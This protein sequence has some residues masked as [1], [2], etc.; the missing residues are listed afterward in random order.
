MVCFLFFC[1]NV[2][3]LFGYQMTVIRV[4][5]ILPLGQPRDIMPTRRVC[6]AVLLRESF[7]KITK[8]IYKIGAIMQLYLFP[9]PE[10]L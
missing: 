10:Q 7:I 6:G 5:F 2:L 9:T 8:D 1:I 4:Y 3:P